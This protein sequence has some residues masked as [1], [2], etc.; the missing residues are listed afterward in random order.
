MLLLLLTVVVVVVVV[1]VV[2]VVLPWYIIWKPVL[3]SASPGRQGG[4][5]LVSSQPSSSQFPG[6]NLG[7]S[8]V[9]QTFVAGGRKR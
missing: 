8:G 9:S 7:V 3:C 4:L 1:A 6:S 2:I 5:V